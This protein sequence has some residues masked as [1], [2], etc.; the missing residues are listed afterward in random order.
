LLGIAAAAA[1]AA[2]V[3]F[4]YGLQREELPGAGLYPF[5]AAS[6]C[7]VLAVIEM[8]RTLGGRAPLAEASSPGQESGQEGPEADEPE[9][10]VRGIELRRLAF[11]GLGFAIQLTTFQ[12]LGFFG[13]AGLAIMTVMMLAERRGA[14]FSLAV[15]ASLLIAIYIVFVVLLRVQFPQPALLDWIKG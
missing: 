1:V 9:W 13:S 4:G 8:L 7:A 11:Y 6:I 10:S 5:A 3:A 15:T 14:R 2:Y 12:V